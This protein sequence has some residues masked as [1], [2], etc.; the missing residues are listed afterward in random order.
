MQIRIRPAAERDIPR[1]LALLSQILTLHE[2]LRPE[3]FIPGSTKYTEKELA[4]ILQDPETPV[5]V[6]ADEADAV[7][8]YAFCVLREPPP[9]HTL[10]PR[11]EFFLDDL[12][13]DETL[14]GRGIGEALFRHVA[15]YARGNGC[16]DLTLNVWTGNDAA[17]RFYEKMGMRP[18]ETLMELPLL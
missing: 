5:F 17:R 3:L 9:S 12:C 2:R 8:G 6:A 18:K 13:V 11:R 16:D 7:C 14:R 10:R 1:L 4:A 15:A